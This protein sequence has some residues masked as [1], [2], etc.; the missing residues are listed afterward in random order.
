M[1]HPSTIKSFI[2]IGDY[3]P[4]GGSAY[5]LSCGLGTYPFEGDA[6]HDIT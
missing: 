3:C 1:Q 6:R 4:R 5:G 2:E